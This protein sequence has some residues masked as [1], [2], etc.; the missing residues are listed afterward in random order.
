M[1]FFLFTV[2]HLFIMVQKGFTLYYIFIDFTTIEMKNLLGI[3]GCGTRYRPKAKFFVLQTLQIY[4][5]IARITFRKAMIPFIC[6]R[7]S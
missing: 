3:L 7:L 6:T 1:F 4:A 5:P 2:K